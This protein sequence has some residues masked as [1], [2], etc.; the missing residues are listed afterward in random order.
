MV[1]ILLL[2]V[3]LL[4]PLSSEAAYKIYLKN[5]SVITGV[6]SYEKENKDIV[7]YFGGGMV[8]LPERDV[9]R[10]EE[11]DVPEKDFRS[12]APSVEE[13]PAEAPAAPVQPETRDARADSLRAELESIN[14]ELKAAED[15][16]A[17][18]RSSIDEKVQKRPRWWQLK[19]FER[20]LEPLQ[21]ELS[22]IQQRK[23]ELTQ[24]KTRIE[25]EL[26]TLE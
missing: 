14:A 12:K 18:V 3:V 24:R 16:E 6:K 19:Q 25:S 21:Q 11:A 13:R 15:D 20:E 9:L 26:K 8:T 5:G 2:V 4:F 10:I 23:D 17:R 22:T 1:Q 7:V